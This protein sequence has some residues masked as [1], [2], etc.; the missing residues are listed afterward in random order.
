M[1]ECWPVERRFEFPGYEVLSL[2]AGGT[3]VCALRIDDRPEVD[4]RRRPTQ[5]D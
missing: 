4:R 1:E 5:T 2:K 3:G